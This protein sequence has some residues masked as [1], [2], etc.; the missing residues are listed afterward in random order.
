VPSSSLERSQPAGPGAPGWR[1]WLATSRGQ[2]ALALLFFGLTE[3]LSLPVL[4]LALAVLPVR[5]GQPLSTVA[6]ELFW[7]AVGLV[8]LIPALTAGY[9]WLRLRRTLAR[10]ASRAAAADRARSP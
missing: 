5:T 6:P 10:T 8:I 9:L 2:L 1:A 4:L 3:A 7:L